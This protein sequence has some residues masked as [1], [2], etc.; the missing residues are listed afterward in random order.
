MQVINWPDTGTTCKIE[1]YLGPGSCVQLFI[2]G[3]ECIESS[4][5]GLTI[6]TLF[7]EIKSYFLSLLGSGEFCH[8][9]VLTDDNG[10]EWQQPLSAPAQKIYDSENSSKRYSQKR[11]MIRQ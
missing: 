10:R 8:Q 3:F 1:N 7:I 6:R 9:G 4:A 2:F 11:F 5:K